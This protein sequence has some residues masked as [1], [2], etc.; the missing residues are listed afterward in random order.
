MANTLNLGGGDWATNATQVLA[1]NNENGHYKPLP[2]NGNRDSSASTI[3]KDQIVKRVGTYE[4]RISYLNNPDGALLTEP[5]AINYVPVSSRGS[6]GNGPGSEIVAQAPDMSQTAIRPVPNSGADR[7]QY[8]I[9]ANTFASGTVFIFSWYRKR[10]STPVDTNYTGDLFQSALINMYSGTATQIESNI[11]GYDRFQITTSIADGATAS[12]YRMYFGNVIGTG[13]S[14]VAYWGQQLEV[15]INVNCKATSLI[16]TDDGSGTNNPTTIG[17]GTVRYHDYV[18]AIRTTPDIQGDFSIYFSFGETKKM[19]GGSE[20]Y[21]VINTSGAEFYLYTNGSSSSSGLNIYS[22]GFSTPGYIFGSN[23]NAAWGVDESKI[24]VTYNSTTNKI[25]YFINGTLFNSQTNALSVGATTSSN[26]G[27]FN[28][29][30]NIVNMRDYRFYN[31]SLSDAKA[32][33]ITTL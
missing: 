22:T 33:A 17:S 16:Y 13:N 31:E 20:Y 21:Y 32:K 5:E 3:T 14:S 15:A 4:P 8:D 7:Y 6:Y 10:F 24:C 29:S 2:Y 19:G 27:S 9:P 28:T 30:A 1:Y 18:Q 26:F 23:Q 25:S 12:I 11:N